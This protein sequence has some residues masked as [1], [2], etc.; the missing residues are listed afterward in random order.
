MDLKEI[1]GEELYSQV[2]E[3]LG[4]KKIMVDDGNFIPKDRFNEVN[5]QKKELKEQVD[6]LNNTL[7]T[8][9]KELEKLKASA[10]G[11]EELQ[12]QLQEYQDKFD[13]TQNE[14]A[15]QLTAKEQEWQQREVNNKKA[16]AMREKLIMEHADSKYIDMLMNQI[17]LNKITEDNGKFIGMDDITKEIKGSYDKLFGKPQILGTGIKDTNTVFEKGSITKE[18]INSMTTEQIN[19]NWEAV[20]AALKE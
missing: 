17:D 4:D 19:A 2:K 6:T 9:S 1:L 15:T 7:K 3:K 10:E 8:N 13:N 20:Q 14:F 16:Y 18:S 11:N 12:K 5:N